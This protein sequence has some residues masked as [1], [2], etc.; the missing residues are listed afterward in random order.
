MLIPEARQQENRSLH[1]WAAIKKTSAKGRGLKTI[2]GM[3]PCFH[4]MR[5]FP[6]NFIVSRGWNIGKHS[7]DSP[8][9]VPL[10]DRSSEG[11]EAKD[12]GAEDGGAVSLRPRPCSKFRG[13]TVS[14]TKKKPRGFACISA[15]QPVAGGT[16]KLGST[17]LRRKCPGTARTTQGRRN[18][19]RAVI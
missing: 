18:Q 14:G 7:V 2:S 19:L 12:G 13:Q 1:N 8:R 15:H 3:R 6:H 17:G 11:V 10:P 16:S 4:P 5:C 9:L